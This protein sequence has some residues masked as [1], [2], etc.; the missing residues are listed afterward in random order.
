MG[1][2]K[3]ERAKEATFDAEIRK[4]HQS[5]RD[6]VQEVAVAAAPYF[7]PRLQATAIDINADTKITYAITDKPLSPDEWIATY[8]HEADRAVAQARLA[9]E[10]AAH[11]DIDGQGFENDPETGE[12]IH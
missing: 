12:R 10:A 3:G 6:K 8:G 2:G 7:H 5:M 4:H 11:S 9:V 1:A